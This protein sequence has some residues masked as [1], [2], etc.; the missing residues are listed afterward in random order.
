MFN[1]FFLSN[2]IFPATPGS[3]QKLSILFPPCKF[4][5]VARLKFSCLAFLHRMNFCQGI[6]TTKFA[7]S[8]FFFNFLHFLNRLLL[9]FFNV[10]VVSQMVRSSAST[11]CEKKIKLAI[12]SF[13]FVKC[14]SLFL[15]VGT[16]KL[17]VPE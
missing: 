15:K 13:V 14:S 11:F 7:R 12:K 2:H 16:A 8:N 5:S 9:F 10:F 1:N 17:L 4:C 3:A 6:P